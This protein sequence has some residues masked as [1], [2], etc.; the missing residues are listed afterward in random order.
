[1]KKVNNNENRSVSVIIPT[2]NRLESLRK[3][4]NALS[5][6]TLLSENFEVIVIDDGSSDGTI[7]HLKGQKKT[8]K[9]NFSYYS[10]PNL[11][12]GAARNLGIKKAKGELIVFTDDDCVADPNWLEALVNSLPDDR[13]CAGI[14][15][16]IVRQQNDLIS[17]YIDD[18]QTMNH[19]IKN[20]TVQYLVTANALYRLSC[21]LEVNGFDTRITWPGGEDPDLSFRLL[22]QGYY[23]ITS[24]L[25]IIRHE[26]RNT[27]KG[28]CLMFKNHG[29]GRSALVQFNRV[30]KRN[31]WWF[32]LKRYIDSPIKYSSRI[33]LKLNVRIV[34]CVL[35]WIH[36]TAFHFGYLSCPDLKN[37][38]PGV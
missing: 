6:Q 21:L 33:D 17:K 38:N 24:S 13:Q 16:V 5:C 9:I 19:P 22:D 23:F 28:L 11:G 37:Q 25:P 1:M 27:L 8:L 35:R 18:T 7:N 4:L 30:K 2:Y 12:P 26:H 15:G 14:G 34:F 32:L 31:N 10:Q 20:N 29:R 36:Y 3:C